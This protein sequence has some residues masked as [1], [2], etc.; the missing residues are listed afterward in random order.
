MLID[1]S[2]DTDDMSQQ[3][4][5]NADRN[6][7]FWQS[8]HGRYLS[9][10]KSKIQKELDSTKDSNNSFYSNHH[11][12]FFI[13]APNPVAIGKLNESLFYKPDVFVWVP[14]GTL[15]SKYDISCLECKSTS[16]HMH[17]WPRP[18]R[19][20]SMTYCYYVIFRRLKC[21]NCKASLSE[22]SPSFISQL[23]QIIQDQFPCEL[24]KRS[25][26]D[27]DIVSIMRPSF[28]H[29]MGPHSFRQLLVE[30]HKKRFNQFELDYYRIIEDRIQK[31]S[32]DRSK[33]AGFSVFSD[34]SKYAGSVPSSGYLELIYNGWM[35]RYTHL[36]EKEMQKLEVQV[37]S[38][39]HSHELPKHFATENGQPIFT[40]AYTITN[41]YNQVVSFSLVPSKGHEFTKPVFERLAYRQ[42]LLNLE[43]T[44][45]YFTDDVT[46]DKRALLETIPSLSDIIK[47]PRSN[48]SN[49]VLPKN[50]KV[51]L[52]HNSVQADSWLDKFLRLEA[53]LKIH[54]GFDCEWNFDT[55]T[56]ERGCVAL[57]QIAYDHEIGLIHISKIGI[58]SN[59]S[60]FLMNENIIKVGRM[61]SLDL[62][63]IER[64]LKLQY[65]QTA[66]I[67]LGSFCRINGLV[68]DGRA[69]LAAL[70]EKTLQKT[71]LK[72]TTVRCSK[73]T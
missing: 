48:Y 20:I 6:R 32:I 33:V 63:K 42:K 55:V 31:K 72:E 39:D 21:T 66:I 46:C 43:P 9:S 70:V 64:D 19:I 22:I 44:I 10:V 4:T 17:E 35:E 3:L 54:V 37:L 67:E 14:W 57:I 12:E 5:S 49:L 52:F 11:S 41:Q 24:S 62:K 38:G 47:K 2:T 61:V 13:R 7:E 29:G 45:A 53:N 69:G 28:Q 58:P 59:L 68:K 30:M 56:Y 50:W 23:P 25:G 34:K 18:R 73:W 65:N 36:F 60:A 26:L 15:V 51:E 8:E 40:A 1:Y 16:L 71:L 27:K